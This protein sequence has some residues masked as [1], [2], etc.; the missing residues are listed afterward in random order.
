MKKFLIPVA[1]AVVLALAA[2]GGSPTSGADDVVKIDEHAQ[3]VF[4]E[5]NALSGS[6]RT[7]ALV[8]AAQAE[9]EL[10]IY[11]S[12]S[13][14][15]DIADAFSDKYDIDVNMYRGNSESVLQRV[16]QESGAGY[17]GVDLIE[18]NAG[19]LNVLQSEGLLYP[20][21]SEFRDQ[22]REEGKKEAWTATRFNVFVV[23]WN[24]DNVAPG[25]EPTSL[26]DF[27]LPEWKGRVSMEVGDVDWFATIYNYYLE[28][29]KSEAEVD[30]FFADLAAD[31]KAVKGHTVQAEL[32][33]AGEFDAGVSMYSHSVDEGED[34]GKPITWRPS[35]GNPVEPLVL[36]PNGAALAGTAQHP[37]AALLFL[38]FL[39]SSEG[40]QFI[41]DDY[42]IGSV[43]TADDPLAGLEV[44]SVDEELLLKDGE[45]W[46][47]KYASIVQA[48]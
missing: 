38:D 5:Y 19:E 33:S 1:G 21:Q 3:E 45:A 26:E 18:T 48:D 4:D 14:L 31:S 12:N 35:S 24:K 16:L 11:T 15:E 34:E 9:G 47:K 17:H 7:D 40:Q 36:R 44:L 41:A 42:R 25:S 22:V 46:D 39:L 20:Y 10:S 43:P 2:C 30:Q 27:L 29:G 8:A 28:Q 32:L 23:A 6:D 13:D 37:A